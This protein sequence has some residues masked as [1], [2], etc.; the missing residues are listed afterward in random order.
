MNSKKLK[1]FQDELRKDKTTVSSDKKLKE[2][3]ELNSCKTGLPRSG[4]PYDIP[5]DPYDLDQDV[6]LTTF[7]SP[8]VVDVNLKSL[9]LK[10]FR[11]GVKKETFEE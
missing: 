8:R 11:D 9:E 6:K 10:Y 2:I 4:Q 3:V 5:I 1:K 7:Q